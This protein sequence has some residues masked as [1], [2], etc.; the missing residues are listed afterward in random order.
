MSSA[1]ES[2]EGMLM[3]N[4]TLQFS[5]STSRLDAMVIRVL[6]GEIEAYNELMAETE[7]RVLGLAWKILGNKEQAMDACQE[8]FLRAYKSLHSYRIGESFV[9]WVM[10]ITANICR[11]YLKK[12]DYGATDPQILESMPATDNENAE[13]AVLQRQ[14]KGIVQRALATLSA[15]ERQAIVLRDMEGLST[16]ETAKMLGIKSGTVRSQIATARN[17]IKKFCQS[18]LHWP[19]GG[20][21]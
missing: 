15:S 21:P 11:D 4:G 8:G 10:T 7:G 16:E 12:R 5:S 20:R 1:V 3:Q 17:K 18:I 13:E 2:M 14:R 9:A 19:K 6:D